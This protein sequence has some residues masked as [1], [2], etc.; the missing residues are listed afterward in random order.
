[1]PYML[2][3]ANWAQAKARNLYN[4]GYRR[5][6]TYKGFGQMETMPMQSSDPL[7]LAAQ[8]AVSDLFNLYYSGAPSAPTGAVPAAG[9][10]S[11][12][13]TLLLIGGGILA[14]V[15]LVKGSGHK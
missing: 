12:L 9:I 7:D 5:S 13:P 11:S 8:Q 1:M 10:T 6:G 15:L 4:V 3:P 2:Q 14:V